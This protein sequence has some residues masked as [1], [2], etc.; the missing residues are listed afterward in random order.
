MSPVVRPVLRYFGGKWRLAPWI[1][2]HFPQHRCYV[3]PFGGGASVLL[4]KKPSKVE[5][6]NDKAG[7]VVNFFRVLRDSPEDLISAL[8][9]TPFAVDEYMVCREPGGYPVEDARRFFVRSWGG[10]N[11]INGSDRSRGWRRTSERDV[12]GQ[13]NSAAE[14]LSIAAARLRRVAIDNLDWTEILARYDSPDTLF[15]VDPPY[16]L[17]SCKRTDPSDGYAV[18]ELGDDGHRRL[19]R[20]LHDLQ[21]AVVLSG[22]PNDFYTD[23]LRSWAKHSRPGRTMQH[24]ATVETLWIRRKR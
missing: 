23:Q 13:F 4:R 8:R 10:Y 1:I 17:S 18:H 15:Y 14:A 21:G 9:L 3:E 12:A 22:Y 6:Y 24:N 7:S 2:S 20:Q 19:V 11:G 5:V 16:W